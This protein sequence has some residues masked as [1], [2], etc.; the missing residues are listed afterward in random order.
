[1]QRSDE[2]PGLFDITYQ[3][4]HTCGQH[5]GHTSLTQSLEQ[6]LQIPTQNESNQQ[7]IINFSKPCLAI[8][9]HMSCQDEQ[10]NILS[11][12][13]ISNAQAGLRSENPNVFSPSSNSFGGP[14]SSGFGTSGASDM[15]FFS[16]SPNEFGT[17]FGGVSSFYE[18]DFEINDVIS[19][20]HSGTS[21]I[22]GF[23]AEQPTY[24]FNSP[25]P[26]S[27]AKNFIEDKSIQHL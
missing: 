11:P 16:M 13:S 25:P 22:H 21:A 20:P 2:D 3:G 18:L 23:A 14:F 27:N 17:D 4:E 26:S 24:P 19:T 1:V 5:P 6:Q 12:P 9:T 7:S 10:N 8:E 15:N